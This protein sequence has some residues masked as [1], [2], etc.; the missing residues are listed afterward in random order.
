[1]T[2][3]SR[4]DPVVS[5]LIPNSACYLEKMRAPSRVRSRQR[6]FTLTELMVVVAMVGVLA[7][8]GVASF[9]RQVSASKTS[10]A[11]SV[12][13]AIRAAEEAYR[14]ENLVYL[15]VSTGNHWYPSDAFDA[16]AR[17]WELKDGGHVDLTN[18]RLLG[19]RV[20]Q[21]VQFG[22]LVDAGQAEDAVPALQLSASPTIGKPMEPW[23]LIQAR[24]DA[25]GDGKYCNVAAAS[26]TQ[27]IFMENEGE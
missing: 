22:Y 15:D 24:A 18:W 27:E 20:T 6:G 8:V 26:W 11:T 16:A 25:D 21:P 9:R 3:V 13:Q 23:Y 2:T 5:G 7:T 1:M 19:A 4:S 14:S 10:E 12:V 17:S